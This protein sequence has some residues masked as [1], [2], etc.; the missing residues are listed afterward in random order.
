[1]NNDEIQVLGTGKRDRKLYNLT[2]AVVAIVAMV[3]GAGL[4]WAFS[5]DR[6]EKIKTGEEM[7]NSTIIAEL[8]HTVDSL[9][10]DK[11]DSIDAVQG[12]VIVM[13]VRTGKILSMVGLERNFEGKL[14]P[15][16]N[17]AY[18]QEAGSLM[19]PASMLAVL[20]SGKVT[21][22]PSSSLVKIAGYMYFMAQSLFS[23]ISIPAARRMFRTVP[24]LTSSLA[25]RPTE[26]CLP[27][28]GLLY[29]SWLDPLR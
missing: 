19:E 12:Q 15:C 28:I 6:T 21:I 26:N 13:D 2:M 4:Y 3:I 16:N 29:I 20:E 27:V 23:C 24:F 7:G 22:I 8:Q 1:M 18:Q 10:R 5:Q 25:C 9:L 14:Q 11:M 17:F